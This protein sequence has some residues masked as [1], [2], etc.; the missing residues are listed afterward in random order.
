MKYILN[1]GANYCFIKTKQT[2]AAI[3]RRKAYLLDKWKQID[4]INPF[5]ADDEKQL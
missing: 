1:M 4:W 3:K 5:V 2:Y